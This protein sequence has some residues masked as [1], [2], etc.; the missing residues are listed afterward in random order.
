MSNNIAKRKVLSAICHGSIFFSITVLGIGVPIAI[1]FISDDEIVQ[2]NAKEAFNFHLNAW[3]YGIIFGI[4]TLVLIGWLLLGIL[5]IVTVVMPII[6][7]VK[8]LT[9]PNKV[10]RYPFIL[11]VL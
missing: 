4:L 5:G 8:V 2:D 3:L 9:N 11:R 6:A 1:L 7:I 10:F